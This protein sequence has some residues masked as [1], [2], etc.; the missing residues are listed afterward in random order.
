MPA[1]ALPRPHSSCEHSRNQSGRF[2]P[3]T[4]K[5]V[6][7]FLSVSLSHVLVEGG[8][9]DTKRFR[10]IEDGYLCLV[11]YHSSSHDLRINRLPVPNPSYH[12]RC[13]QSGVRS[14]ISS[15][16]ISVSPAIIVKKGLSAGVEVSTSKVRIWRWLPLI[17]VVD[18]FQQ[19]LRRPAKPVTT[20]VSPSPRYSRNLSNSGR[21]F[22]LDASS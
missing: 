1:I 7:S 11:H 20:R 4:G 15:R 13:A 12:P 19:F 2:N 8:S 18:D 3:V 10:D 9:R 16:S 6:T 22:T 21:R 14:R 5:L 17:R